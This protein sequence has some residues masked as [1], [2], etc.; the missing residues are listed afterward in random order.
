MSI[1]IANI[2]KTAK[3]LDSMLYDLIL[4]SGIFIPINK[5]TFNYKNYQVSKNTDGSWNVFLFSDRKH[6]IANTFL[7]VTAFT[8]CKLHEKGQY[9]RVDEILEDD[10]IFEKNYTD[11]LFYKNTVKI[12]NDNV[13]KDTALWRYEIVHHK[14]KEA[15]GR[16]DR[17]FYSSIA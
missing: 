17:H 16:I 7:K 5:N 6:H 12:S 8:V 3:E 11:S 15:K 9:Q 4:K 2:K 1:Q 13:S 14:A 10:R